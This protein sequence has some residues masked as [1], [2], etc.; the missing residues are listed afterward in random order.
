MGVRGRGKGLYLSGGVLKEAREGQYVLLFG[1]QGFAPF[2]L[3]LY[4]K[5]VLRKFNTGRRRSS[6]GAAAHVA[7]AVLVFTLS[8]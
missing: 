5:L 2:W 4:P 8:L 1:C 6:H 3:L 7:H